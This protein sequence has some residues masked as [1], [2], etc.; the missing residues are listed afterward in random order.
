MT[1]GNL[2]VFAGRVWVMFTNSPYEYI[3]YMLKRENATII[4]M[5]IGGRGRGGI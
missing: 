4:F 1:A 3:V 5:I 2:K